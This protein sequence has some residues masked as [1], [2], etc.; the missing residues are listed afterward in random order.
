[1]PEEKSAPPKNERK[2]AW[3]SPDRFQPTGKWSR[4]FKVKGPIEQLSGDVRTVRN[5]IKKRRENRGSSR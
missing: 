2:P 1:M 3:Y 5:Y 4:D